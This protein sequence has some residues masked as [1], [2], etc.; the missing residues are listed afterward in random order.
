MVLA[1]SPMRRWGKPEEI[2]N[3]VLFLASDEASYVTG[4]ML[5]ADGG[6]SAGNQIGVRWR[7]VPDG[8]DGIPVPWL[9]RLQAQEPNQGAE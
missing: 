4:E 3:V 9:S 8:E 2:A 7:P 5:M 6:Q 1:L